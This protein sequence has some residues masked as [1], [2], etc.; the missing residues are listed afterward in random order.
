MGIG[1][2]LF[3]HW[4]NGI[5]TA[6]TGISVR[7]KSQN[8]NGIGVLLAYQWDRDTGLGNGIGNPPSGASFF[9][10]V[11]IVDE[12]LNSVWSQLPWVFQFRSL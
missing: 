2:C 3:L 9:S 6:G 10:W 4:E 5:S 12:L 8:G 11:E 7:K 1:I